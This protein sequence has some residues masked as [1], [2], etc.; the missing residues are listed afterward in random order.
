MIWKGSQALGFSPVEVCPSPC[1]WYSLFNKHECHRE[2][3]HCQEGCCH[4]FSIFC[5][6][7]CKSKPIFKRSFLS[8]GKCVCACIYKMIVKPNTIM[9][10]PY[11]SVLSKLN[12]EILTLE[13][14]VRLG[15]GTFGRQAMSVK[16]VKETSAPLKKG[17]ESS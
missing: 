6:D 7:F 5:I 4:P 11:R 16:T 17:V 9:V 12:V 8:D 3:S 10:W 1:R 14:T 15:G 13:V 2:L